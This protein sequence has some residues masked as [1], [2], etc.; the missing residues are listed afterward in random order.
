M[1]S[2]LPFGDQPIE[3]TDQD[4][5]ERAPLAGIVARQI[6]SLDASQGAVVGVL[7]AWGAGKTS[8]LNLILEQLGADPSVTV[9]EFNPWMFS[10]V[11]QIT[12][13]L[14]AEL[15][16]TL[17]GKS[18][19]RAARKRVNRATEVISRYARAVQ[20]GVKVIPGV[21]GVFDAAVGV[22]DLTKMATDS[23][24]S[25]TALRT[26]AQT[27]LANL[28]GLIVV[29]IDDIDRLSKAEV[30]DLFRAVRLTAQFP[31]VVYVL[32][33]DD[34]VVASALREDGFS[35]EAYLEKIL[36]LTVPVPA[37]TSSQIAD[38]FV[39]SLEA[40]VSQ[41]S[42]G[43]FDADVWRVAFPYAIAPLLKTPRDP[44][45]VLAALPI[46]MGRYGGE[47]PQVDVITLECVRVLR[48]QL[49]RSLLQHVG[50]LTSKASDMAFG[51]Q[52]GSQDRLAALWAADPGAPGVAQGVVA[53]LFPD[54][55]D[56][57]LGVPKARRTYP[58][59][60]VRAGLDLYASG[61]FPA[62]AAIPSQLA[63]IVDAFG[64]PVLLPIAFRLV[65]PSR[66]RD[67]LSQLSGACEGIDP[68]LVA[69]TL[70]AF[71]DQFARVPESG[72]GGFFDFGPR[73]D[74]SRRVY[75]LL[76]RGDA[77]T[78]FNVAKKYV[79]ASQRIYPAH[80]LV[81]MVGHRENAGHEIV[82]VEQA[83]ELE[84]LVRQRIEHAGADLGEERQLLSL[85][86]HG[87]LPPEGLAEP[88]VPALRDPRVASALF[89][90]AVSES[91]ST[92]LGS[93]RTE[94]RFG[95]HWDLLCR[96][97]G[98][99]DNVRGAYDLIRSDPEQVMRAGQ[100]V[101]LIQKYLSGWRPSGLPERQQ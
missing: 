81:M 91:R 57:N 90:S 75:Q 100:S 13:A 7:G 29:A 32:C 25:I 97:M 45:R 39:T 4:L 16:A 92:E 63:Q 43:P 93:G 85:L 70:P 79:L 82:T 17:R 69:T 51:N 26:S 53:A 12:S 83:R 8:L 99:E 19:T 28:E 56:S 11:E 46:A 87:L 44:K 96:L 48:P 40:L 86:Y 42:I 62:G 21:G 36:T 65:E 59:I 66:L 84:A 49:H 34:A 88:V 73:A 95:L 64:D 41:E 77:D 10:G 61:Q 89:S 14:L 33:M 5:L 72:G 74:V 54:S 68:S 37:V 50:L 58:G 67:T 1:T 3:T 15:V 71:V 2:Q 35:G 55:A 31:N 78:V 30:R 52:G 98:G 60:S 80:E 9:V 20:P 23:D 76:Q 6:A 47:L 38:L 24:T 94:S 22:V 27:S 18:R 101:D